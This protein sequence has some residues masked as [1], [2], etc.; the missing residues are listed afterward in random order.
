MFSKLSKNQCYNL[1]SWL[2]P[3]Y[4]RSFVSDKFGSKILYYPTYVKCC[5]TKL[6]FYI[7]ITILVLLFQKNPLTLFGQ[8]S[9][10]WL[11]F[12]TGVHMLC[13]FLLD[14]YMLITILMF[15]FSKFC[16]LNSF[17]ETWPQNLNLSKLTKAW[18]RSY[19]VAILFFFLDHVRNQKFFGA[20]EV[21]K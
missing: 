18:H 19:K 15:L 13:K 1:A 2:Q 21:L 9:L 4:Y 12:D 3:K 20:S 14:I 8:Y 17:E 16:C 6:P 10:D 5:R 7:L 11:G